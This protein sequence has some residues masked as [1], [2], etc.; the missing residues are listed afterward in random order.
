MAKRRKGNE[1]KSNNAGDKA[2]E[3]GIGE[4]KAG[5]SKI[6]K[7]RQRESEE[8][9]QPIPS[10]SK[11]NKLDTIEEEKLTLLEQKIDYLTMK[12]EKM[13]KLQTEGNDILEKILLYQQEQTTSI[14]VYE[15]KLQDLQ[16]QGRPGL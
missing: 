4:N 5:T 2:I 16:D 6:S 14:S 3:E 13:I 12:V 7:K 11:R 15:T 8:P 10:S 1:S 9:I